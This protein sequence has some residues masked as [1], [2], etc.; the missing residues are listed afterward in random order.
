MRPGLGTLLVV[1]LAV[2]A[3]GA[4]GAFGV[5]P[6]AGSDSAD[7]SPEASGN[8]PGSTDAQADCDGGC[9]L[10]ADDFEREGEVK[11]P[12]T[13][14]RVSA[15]SIALAPNPLGP[16]RVLGAM[17]RQADGTTFREAFVS[18]T[19][20]PGAG[21]RVELLVNIGSPSGFGED[22]VDYCELASVTLGGE[23]IVALS[24]SFQTNIDVVLYEPGETTGKSAK[25][26]TAASTWKQVALTI[27]WKDETVTVRANVA[28]GEEATV[29]GSLRAGLAGA[30]PAV[31]VGLR[32]IGQ[33][34]DITMHADDVVVRAL[35]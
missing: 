30:E 34:G 23:R 22:P 24:Y 12:W 2:L 6:N 4:C 3:V 16:G 25:L 9:V 31:R 1:S 8:A 33:T 5:A 32:C 11:G 15:G 28:G 26:N 29:A 10:F 35:P 7:A 20:A 17:L 21:L 19:L 14:L 13:T 18:K 27:A